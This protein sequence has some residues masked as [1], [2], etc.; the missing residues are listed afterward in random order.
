MY[1]Q[2]SQSDLADGSLAVI[3]DI[4]SSG[5]CRPSPGASIPPA[6]RPGFRPAFRLMGPGPDYLIDIAIVECIV[7]QAE[8]IDPAYGVRMQRKLDA[9]VAAQVD[10]PE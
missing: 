8:V 10:L 2:I 7:W 5:E 1:R 4:L 9:A 3:H 6:F